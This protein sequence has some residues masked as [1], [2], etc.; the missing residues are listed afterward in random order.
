MVSFPQVDDASEQDHLKD[1]LESY[2]KKLNVPVH[3]HRTG[4]RSGLIRARWFYWTQFK[5]CLRDD[6]F[7]SI[8]Y[9]RK[10]LA[11]INNSWFFMQIG[12]WHWNHLI[13]HCPFHLIKLQFMLMWWGNGKEILTHKWWPLVFDRNF[14]ALKLYLSIFFSHA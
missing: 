10:Q 11:G 6:K 5:F 13:C 4:Q 2:V 1:Q 8:I 7:L 3:V 14:Q 12:L 9:L